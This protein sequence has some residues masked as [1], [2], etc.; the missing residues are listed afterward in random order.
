MKITLD[1]VISKN[2]YQLEA[3]GEWYKPKGYDLA[4]TNID[5]DA[6]KINVNLVYG[7][8]D[9]FK[10]MILHQFNEKVEVVSC[11]AM[12][13]QIEEN[14]KPWH[15]VLIQGNEW[16]AQD[17]GT[18][19]HELHHL[20]HHALEEKGVTYGTGGEEIYAYVQ[21]H[22]MELVVRAFVEYKKA[23]KKKKVNKSKRFS[24]V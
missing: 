10:K 6:L 20:T 8:L 1:K 9:E 3:I 15:F 22:F 14:S 4:M 5:C 23:S 16:T 18:I 24:Q 13:I 19:C 7:T 11:I 2:T 17:Y 21:G 12:Y